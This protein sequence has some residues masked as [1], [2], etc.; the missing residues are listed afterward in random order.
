MIDFVVRIDSREIVIG[1]SL[2]R[3]KLMFK[4]RLRVSVSGL[5]NYCYAHGSCLV[6]SCVGFFPGFF[7]TTEASYNSLKVAPC[8]RELRTNC[9]VLLETCTVKFGMCTD[10]VGRHL[11]R[12][13]GGVMRHPGEL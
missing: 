7:I 10:I 2:A 1:R 8:L 6:V 12:K 4:T 5:W 13:F 9:R 11:L 3:E